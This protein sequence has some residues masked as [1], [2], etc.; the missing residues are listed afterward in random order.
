[1]LV[2]AIYAAHLIRD[3]PRLTLLA[4]RRCMVAPDLGDPARFATG[5][6]VSLWL[7]VSEHGQ[8]F[9]AFRSF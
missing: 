4:C 1:M 9:W 7:E 3:A 6:W 2:V 8:T 5:V